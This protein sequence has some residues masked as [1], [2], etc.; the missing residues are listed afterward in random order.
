MTGSMSGENHGT[1]P[2]KVKANGESDESEKTATEKMQET[3]CASGEDS[4]KASAGFLPSVTVVPPKESEETQVISSSR[5][6]ASPPVASRK[7]FKRSS[8]SVPSKLMDG[9]A[10]SLARRGR[11]HSHLT[12]YGGNPLE[13]IWDD[14]HGFLD[15][16]GG[17][18]ELGA[19]A[20]P[21]RTRG[22]IRHY[23]TLERA[24]SYSNLTTP[25]P[26]FRSANSTRPPPAPPCTTTHLD[27]CRHPINPAGSRHTRLGTPRRNNPHPVGLHFQSPYNRDGKVRSTACNAAEPS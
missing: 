20:S 9:E 6:T 19:S 10:S 25:R 5:E 8:S 11:A 22:E 15:G 27:F 16:S 21:R 2:S 23:G 24:T 4:D 26:H 7:T 3:Q 14:E 13:S 18:S 17:R 1:Q 12:L